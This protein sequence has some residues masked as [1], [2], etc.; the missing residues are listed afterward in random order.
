[1]RVSG[2]NTYWVFHWGSLYCDT[3]DWVKKNR[4]GGIYIYVI[5]IVMGS[6]SRGRLKAAG[7]TAVGGG[8]R[9]ISLD[10]AITSPS[11]CG[12]ATLAVVQYR[13]GILHRGIR[14]SV[15]L[16]TDPQ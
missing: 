5:V 1:M 11:S 9:G 13:R 3:R 8:G 16:L 7:A 2:G 4:V 10:I 15:N 6:S 14:S 12:S